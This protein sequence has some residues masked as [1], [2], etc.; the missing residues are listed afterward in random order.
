M[1]AAI[2]GEITGH[3]LHDAAARV[4]ARRHGG[5]FEPESRLLVIW[6][7]TPCMVAG[8]TLIGFSIESGYHYM[9]TA[10]A[11]GLYVFGIMITTVGLTAYNLDSYPE[12]SGEVAAWIN[13][14]R[15]TGGFIVTYFQIKWADAIG[16]KK[17]FG[18]Q[19]GIVAAMFLL[20]ITL[21]FRGKAL[22]QWSGNLGFK[23]S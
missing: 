21:Q 13:F 4:Y 18:T 14:A 20:I 12:A 19:A 8:L 5:K 7:S 16:A 22:R 6:L 1:I 15:T 23:T 2:L 11:W 10:L 17:S 9:L 3:W